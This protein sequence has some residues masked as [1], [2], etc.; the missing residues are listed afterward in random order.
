MLEAR[1]VIIRSYK[2][3]FGAL[4]PSVTSRAQDSRSR[5][6]FFF[7]FSILKIAGHLPLKEKGPC[8]AYN[9]VCSEER[10]WDSHFHGSV[11]QAQIPSP[12]WTSWFS[13]TAVT[14]DFPSLIP[15]PSCGI[16]V[17]TQDAK[18]PSDYA[19]P[20]S[21]M[22]LLSLWLGPEWPVVR[23]HSWDSILPWALVY[24]FIVAT[25]NKPRARL[26]FEFMATWNFLSSHDTG[27]KGRTDILW[28]VWFLNFPT[29]WKG[30]LVL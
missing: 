6:L 27:G 13:L 12:R 29:K 21:W 8:F 7:F 11:M 10:C 20:D 17:S 23:A 1:T 18:W 2:R 19:S 24:R 9:G 4:P 3:T 16:P 30:K 15:Y 25:S 14:L 5:S 28:Q 26:L 22:S